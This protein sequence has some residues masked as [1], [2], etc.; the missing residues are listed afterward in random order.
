MRI[1]RGRIEERDLKIEERK[2]KRIK[3]KDL[4]KEI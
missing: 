4:R 2:D 3:G 1:E